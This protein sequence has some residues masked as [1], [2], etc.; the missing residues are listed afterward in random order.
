[1]KGSCLCGDVSFELLGDATD[2]YQCHCSL[3]RKV[4]GAGGNVACIVPSAKFSW[5]TGT[6]GISSFVRDSGY[7]SD[8]C[9][10]C[11][12]PVPNPTRNGEA[13][14]IPVG[15]FDGQTSARV[16]KH[17]FVGSK[18]AWDEIGG[19]AIQFHGRPQP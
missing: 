8:F 1:M 17:V 10:R 5:L 7:R 6:G 2:L 19:S 13:V 11:G 4:T 18:A 9:S 3:C 14:W 12:S 16:T 15:L